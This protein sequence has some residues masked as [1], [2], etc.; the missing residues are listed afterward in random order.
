MPTSK[1]V[2]CRCSIPGM[3]TQKTITTRGLA[4]KTQRSGGHFFGGRSLAVAMLFLSFGLAR[5]AAAQS[6]LIFDDE[7][8]GHSLDTSKWMIETLPGHGQGTFRAESVF[9]KPEAISVDDH[10]LRIKTERIPSTDPK[11][12]YVFPLRTGRI[13]THQ[14]FLFGKFEFRAKL[15]RGAGLWPAIWLRTPYGQPFNGEIDVFEGFGSHPNVIQS[16]LHTWSNGA[17]THQYCA[18]LMVQPTPD[19]QKFHLPNCTRVDQT[20]HLPSDLASDYHVYTMEW[21]PNQVTWSIDGQVY[22][23]VQKEIPQVPMTIV[24]NTAFAHNWDGGSPDTTILP[25]SFDIKYVRVYGNPL[26]PK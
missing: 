19:A 10:T 20:I 7:F 16:T 13:Q 25:Q 24:L 2:N 1:K 14:A 5:V 15:P 3:A 4:G 8:P 6:N 11:T 9:Y 12:G 26:P 17:E 22:F 23:Q 21:Q 18:W